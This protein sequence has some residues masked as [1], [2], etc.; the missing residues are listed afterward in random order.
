MF[1]FSMSISDIMST[2][3]IWQDSMSLAKSNPG[4]APVAVV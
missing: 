1:F 3:L 4:K 2:P